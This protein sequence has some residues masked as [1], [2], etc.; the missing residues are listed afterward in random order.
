MVLNVVPALHGF[1]QAYEKELPTLFIVSQ[2]VVRSTENPSGERSTWGVM[3]R[4][5]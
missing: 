4:W 3:K 1:L 2:V 5:E